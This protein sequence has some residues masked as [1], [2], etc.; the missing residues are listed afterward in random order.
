VVFARYGRE[1][2]LI[3]IHSNFHQLSKN[4]QLAGWNI[5]QTVSDIAVRSLVNNCVVQFGFAIDCMLDE[6]LYKKTPVQPEHGRL[7]V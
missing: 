3:Q 7:S 1:Y 5:S 2:E 4:K 6:Y